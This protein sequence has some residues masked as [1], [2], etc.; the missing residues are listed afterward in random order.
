MQT[1]GV[2]IIMFRIQAGL[3]K[4]YGL[5]HIARVQA[6]GFEDACKTYV[7]TQ[8]PEDLKNWE[9]E[10]ACQYHPVDIAAWKI[11]PEAE[12]KYLDSPTHR[13]DGGFSS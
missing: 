9:A 8:Y 12:S 6:E 1:Y 2:Q 11:P 13:I 7:N 4:P 3:A 10:D 5:R